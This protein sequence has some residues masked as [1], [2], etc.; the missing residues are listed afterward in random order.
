ML[1]LHLHWLLLQQLDDPEGRPAPLEDE[2]FQQACLLQR[3]P[4]HAARPEEARTVLYLWVP[5]LT[6]GG[7]HYFGIDQ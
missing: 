7:Q 2:T 1:I 5:E 4:E 6:R 3:M